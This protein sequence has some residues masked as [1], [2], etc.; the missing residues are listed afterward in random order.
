MTLDEANRAVRATVERMNALY[1]SPVFDECAVL[2]LNDLGGRILTYNGPRKDDFQKNFARDFEALRA[3]LASQQFGI[4]DF[5]FAR[6]GAGTRFDAF[7]V[8]GRGLYLICNN[9]RA[10]MEDITKDARWLEAQVPFVEL[11]DKF[12]GNPLALG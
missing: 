6:Q 4:G 5:E 9:T 2:S 8:L 7:L 12:R 1:S 10:S 3:E 11:S